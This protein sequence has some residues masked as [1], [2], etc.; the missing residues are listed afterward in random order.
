MAYKLIACY[1]KIAKTL[2]NFFHI[3]C[4]DEYQDTQELQ[5]EI[6]SKIVTAKL[7]KTILFMVGDRDQAIYGSLGGVARSLAEIK[8]SF[9]NISI[10]EL[11]LSGNYRSTQRVID[12]YRH[13]QTTSIDI[14]SMCAYAA[15]QSVIT[16]NDTIHKD[17]LPEHIAAIIA[18]KIADGTQE[19]E[20]CVLAPQWWLVIP[21][22][23][24]LKQLLP[25]VNFDAVGLSPLIKSKENIWYK[26]ARLFLVAPAPNM[27]FVRT[28]WANEMV[29]DLQ[30]MGLELF[31]GEQ[32]K[33]KRLLKTFNAIT[34]DQINGLEYL[35][36]CFLQ[37]LAVL[38]IDIDSNEHLKKHWT[39]FLEGTK[40]RLDDPD[41]NYAKDIQS[42][43]RLFRHNNGV[44]VNT[45]HGIKGEEFNTVIAFGL[46]EGFVP[47][48]NETDQTSAAKKLLYVICSRAKKDLHLIAENGR[49][50]GRNPRLATSQLNSIIFK[51]D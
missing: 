9:G 10:N 35:E 23:K 20:I 1:P 48:R 8:A 33:A 45:C 46:L 28:R 3:I 13:Y 19:K 22:G 29:T 18:K 21:M 47:N 15:Q 6:L 43:R 49:M 38:E 31:A 2:N 5:Y 36:D 12:Y 16:Y 27:Y 51:Y 37:L 4:V 50:W 24:K 11:E 42:F 41:N 7:N 39:F 17:N 26:V 14:K 40:R 44:V 25:N 32:G 34:S 30:N